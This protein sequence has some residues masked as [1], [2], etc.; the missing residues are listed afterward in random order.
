MPLLP[1][2]MEVD[3]VENMVINFG[4][5]VIKQEVLDDNIIL[6]IK[7]PVPSDKKP[8]IESAD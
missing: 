8:L 4:W 2:R 3:R 7:K 5:K 1:I 6:T